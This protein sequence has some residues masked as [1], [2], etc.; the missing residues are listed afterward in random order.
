MRRL[1]SG[2]H[3]IL[4][5]VAVLA[6]STFLAAVDH[7]QA[8]R[9]VPVAVHTVLGVA[10]MAP[11]LGHTGSVRRRSSHLEVPGSRRSR[12]PGADMDLVVGRRRGVLAAGT[13][14]RQV[15]LRPS[16]VSWI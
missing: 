3:S 5:A 16:L 14:G 10:R 6:D 12:A 2:C 4:L 8:V 13:E 7:S 11:G 15:V 1:S 9:T